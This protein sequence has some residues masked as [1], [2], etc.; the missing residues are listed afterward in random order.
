MATYSNSRMVGIGGHWLR[1]IMFSL[2]PFGS[3]F[4]QRLYRRGISLGDAIS[5][6]QFHA[7]LITG[8]AYVDRPEFVTDLDVLIAVAIEDHAGTYV[9]KINCRVVDDDEL[10]SYGEMVVALQ[11]IGVFVSQC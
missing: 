10:C 6:D 11:A 8:N 5:L 3:E 7:L 2:G 1:C 9:S 4:I